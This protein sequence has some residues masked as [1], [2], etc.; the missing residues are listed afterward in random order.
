MHSVLINV[1]FDWIWT[2]TR[3]NYVRSIDERKAPSPA[4]NL[5]LRDFFI[6]S[7]RQRVR[8]GRARRRDGVNSVESSEVG[9]GALFGT[10][11]LQ[12]DPLFEPTSPDSVDGSWDKASILHRP[13]PLL[14]LFQATALRHRP[15]CMEYPK[16]AATEREEEEGASSEEV[17]KKSGRRLC[18]GPNCC[19]SLSL[20]PPPTLLSLL[21]PLLGWYPWPGPHPPLPPSNVLQ[22]SATPHLVPR[23]T[24]ETWSITLLKLGHA[25]HDLLLLHHL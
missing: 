23:K 22:C 17:W 25:N 6:K 10:S 13:R 8:G 11:N 2:L 19:L 20:P 9:Q 15:F 16:T 24:L 14:V 4:I 18:Q 12:S 21:L 3:I 7:N 5:L 1:S